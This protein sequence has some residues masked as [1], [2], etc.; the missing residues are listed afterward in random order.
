MKHAIQRALAQQDIGNAFD[1]Y[2]SVASPAV[3]TDFVFELDAC[4]QHIER[5]PGAG[6]LRYAELLDLEGLR[7]TVVNRFPYFIFYV[8]RDDCL[9]VVRVLHQHRDI[10]ELLWE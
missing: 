9:D 4:M 5:F 8:E 2:L 7:C 10:P 3:A 6:S 1:H